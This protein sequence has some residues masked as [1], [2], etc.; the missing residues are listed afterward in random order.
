[1]SLGGGGSPIEDA[2]AGAVRGAVD[3]LGAR[4]KDFL[5]WVA[6]G[7]LRFL[8]DPETVAETRRKKESSEWESLSRF[9]ES[10]D[11]QTQV[12]IGLELRSLETKGKKPRREETRERLVRRYGR[13]GLHVAE[14]AKLGVVT[15]LVNELVKRFENPTDVRSQLAAI[16]TDADSRV[17]FVKTYDS[18][19]EVSHLVEGRL[20]VHGTQLLIAKG[21]ARKVLEE[22]LKR[23][24]KSRVRVILDSG[25][26]KTQSYAILFREDIW[27]DESEPE[28]P[29]VEAPEEP[30]P[31]RRRHRP[32]MRRN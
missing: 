17:R 28:L 27:P 20:E 6:A 4:A 11:L 21:L 18:P 25:P 30:K 13:E 26:D 31:A 12:L 14:L 3:A 1:V 9:L 7:K 19:A 23:L 10:S 2:A 16:L 22:T 8:N 5:A 29:E 15:D 32:L 24:P